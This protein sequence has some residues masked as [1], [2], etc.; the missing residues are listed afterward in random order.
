M[1]QGAWDEARYE[2]RIAL[3]LARRIEDHLG[4]ANVL[5]ALTWSSPGGIAERE[6]IFAEALR[7]ARLVGGNI[8]EFLRDFG[9]SLAN[10]GRPSEALVLLKEALLEF[11]E[12]EDEWRSAT[13]EITLA[14]VYVDLGC[15]DAAEPLLAKGRRTV[16]THSDRYGQAVALFVESKLA[17]TRGQ[18]ER[19]RDLA[20]QARMI[21]DKLPDPQ[22]EALIPNRTYDPDRST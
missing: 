14:G 16:L 21:W 3:K 9:L 11:Q 19:A 12:E 4:A 22:A 10:E 18:L 20:A 15:L 13:V 8:G 7:E 17:K 5:N 1:N 2:L 6:Y